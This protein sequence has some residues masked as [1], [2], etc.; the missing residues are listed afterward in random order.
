MARIFED[1][2]AD[3]LRQKHS[4]DAYARYRPAYLEN[5]EI[6][7]F[8]RRAGI[9]QRITVCE[10]K[11]RFGDSPITMTDITIF[12]EKILVIKENEGK[13][14]DTIFYFWGIDFAFYQASFF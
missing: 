5:K 9:P 8:G 12:H 2:T 14:V 11:L 13:G 10:C 7:V 4:Y 1:A 3:Y 6:D